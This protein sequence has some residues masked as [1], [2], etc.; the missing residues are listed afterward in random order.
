MNFFWACINLLKA[1]FQTYS[2]QQLISVPFSFEG[3]I[4]FRFV[5]YLELKLGLFVPLKFQFR[6]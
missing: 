2:Q 1:H 4:Q 6:Y 3:V 5:N